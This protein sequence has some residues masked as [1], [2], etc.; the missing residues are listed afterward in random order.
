MAV[1]VEFLLFIATEVV[2]LGFVDVSIGVKLI[3][4]C[5]I[6]VYT[7]LFIATLL[8]LTLVSHFWRS[9]RSEVTVYRQ[10]PHLIWYRLTL[11]RHCSK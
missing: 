6:W 10:E 3:A 11:A 2:K 9:G 8:S 4:A 5:Y 7:L 1:N